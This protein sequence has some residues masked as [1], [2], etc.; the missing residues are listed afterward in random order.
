MYL[1]SDHTLDGEA[2]MY[3]GLSSSSHNTPS[4]RIMIELQ[5]CPIDSFG[6]SGGYQHSSLTVRDHLC[7]SSDVCSDNRCTDGHRLDKYLTK[8]F[9][10]G[11][12][13]DE[14]HCP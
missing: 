9:S 7:S 2:G 14:I 4:F 13:D 3:A 10:Q 8:S 6:R 5:D 11:R 1:L 12:V